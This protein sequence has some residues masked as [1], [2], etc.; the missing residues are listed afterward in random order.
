MAEGKIQTKCFHPD[1]TN[2]YVENDVY[3]PNMIIKILINDMIDFLYIN[4]A[5]KVHVRTMNVNALR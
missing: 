4:F 2:M 5:N 1:V 3:T